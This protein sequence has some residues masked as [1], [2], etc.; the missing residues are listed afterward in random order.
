MKK[1]ALY[2]DIIRT[3]RRTLPRFLSIF[4]IVALGVAFY[5]GIRVTEKDMKI[6]ADRQFDES[7]FMDLEVLGTL[8]LSDQDL[9][10]I[11]NLSG[12][13]K[14]EGSYS[15]DTICQKEGEQDEYVTK[16]M[17]VTDELN[18]IEVTDGK[19]PSSQT[20][21]LVDEHFAQENQ[22]KIGDILVLSSGTEDALSDTLK[23]SR[24]KITGI[25]K[26]SAYLSMERGSSDIGSG[27]ISGF[28]IVPKEAFCLDVYTEIYIK[29][30]DA[31]KELSYTDSYDD[32]VARTQ[33]QL[34]GIQ[35]QRNEERLQEIQDDAN[36]EISSQEEDFQKE[37]SQALKE[38]SDAKKQLEDAKKQ[39]DDSEETLNSRQKELE[40][41]EAEIKRGWEEYNSGLKQISE[42]KKKIQSGKAVLEKEEQKL[43]SGENQI[44][45]QEK[46]L[47]ESEQKVQKEEAELKLSQ[48]QLEEKEKTLDQLEEQIAQYE[49][50]PDVSEDELSEMKQQLAEGQ[51]AVQTA[52]QQLDA[53]EKE[54]SAAK[55]Q[56]TES[57]QQLESA[58][59]QLTEG[60]N[61]I[62]ASKQQLKTSEN[63]I[64]KQETSLAQAKQTLQQNEKKIVQGKQQLE[65]GKKQIADAKAEYQSGLKEYQDSEKEAKEEFEKAEKKIQ[66]A[67]DKVNDMEKGSWY[68][69]N[70]KQTQSYVEYGEEAARIGAIG[71]VFP[72]I[73]FLVAA[74]VSLTAMTRMV[75]E[76][77]TQIGTMKALGYGGRDIAAK[78]LI[79]GMAA[80]VTGSVIGAVIGEKILPKIIIEAYKMMYVGLGTVQVPLEAQYTLMAS[81]IAIGVVILATMSVCYKELREKPAQLMRPAA[82]KEGKRIFLERIPFLWKRLSFIWKATMRNMFRYKKRFFM[83]I[84]GIGGS[85]ALMLV[86]FGLKDSISAISDYQFHRIIRYDISIGLKE[87]AG[88]EEKEELL[89]WLSKKDKVTAVK[90]VKETTVDLEANG[91]TRSAAFIIPL[92]L[93][94]FNDYISL[95]DRKTGQKEKLGTDGVILA[96]KTASLLGVEPGDEITINEGEDGSVKVKV[97]ALT[98]NYM[99]NK[100]YMSPALYEKL[101]G[102]EPE[103]T[104]IYCCT[105]NVSKKWENTAGSQILDQNGAGSVSFVSDDAQTMMDM[106]ANLNIVV[107][108]LIVSA[109]LLAFVVLYNLNNI[110]IS[111]RR[112]ELATIKVLGFYDLEV[113]EYVYRENVILTILG[114]IAGMGMGI[115]L[116]RYVILTA[117]VDLIMFGR[118]IYMAS[119]VYSTLLT[120]GFAVM[121]NFLMYFQLKKIDMVESLKST[122]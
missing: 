64:T 72:A 87:G 107:A 36:D 66:D 39:I 79:Y 31:Q 19:M 33:D 58:K 98:E 5:S 106:V 27:S 75:E 44:Q 18:K 6:T 121:I 89:Q 70:R 100:I 76:Q 16:V 54:I 38:L 109:A 12:V 35:D 118:S 81:G 110:N 114:I 25:G 21:C 10:A 91:E 116:H 32:T 102:E 17:S 95:Q 97:A 7:S 34:E 60:R 113:G 82:P 51:E 22:L 29:A 14:A 41:G 8:G 103:A 96:E 120:I 2:K 84:F 56:I 3:I 111:E 61:E 119:Y 20:E 57:R 42:A 40:D 49:K 112:A 78:Y 13:V 73:F 93:K 92:D 80:T 11:Q 43:T 90:E 37:K 63:E 83:M 24:F 62:N 101:Y 52:R 26:S 23:E 104:N 88:E 28:L 30:K 74:L 108:V 45:Q 47:E 65:S 105:S 1:K 69:L 99:M 50:L 4:F 68:I 94:D 15:A 77:R 53:G 117:E 71:K 115:L 122:E 55:Q 46:T 86:G 48:Q 85:M 9:K 67:K 59:Q